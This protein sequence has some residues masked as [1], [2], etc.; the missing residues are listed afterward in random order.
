MKSSDDI[1]LSGE[2]NLDKDELLNI[3]GRLR[4]ALDR[5]VACCKSREN[6]A[7]QEQKLLDVVENI[8]KTGEHRNGNS[9][10]CGGRRKYRYR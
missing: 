7:G 8:A 4:R 3:I 6:Y 9:T 1:N 2:A 10:S 5:I